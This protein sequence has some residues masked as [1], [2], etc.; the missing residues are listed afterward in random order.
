MSPEFSLS[1]QYAADAPEVPRW[2]VRRWVARALE[3]A[4]AARGRTGLPTGEARSVS[5]TLRFVGEVEGRELNE[6]YRGRNYAT[7]VLTFEYGVDPDG[8][9]H[10][11]IVLCVPVLHRE[12]DA[13]H[14]PLLHHAAHL[15][16]HGVLH[17]LGYDHID[18]DEA[19]TME[20]LE[21]AILASQHIP[22]PYTA[23]A[24]PN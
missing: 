8:C 2:R 13:Q 5:L 4:M 23:I 1:I 6:A 24:M 18:P 9:L 19:S 14:K 17:A 21:T 3:H 22:D 7:N 20:T 12:A 10:G 11:D 15:V 16:S